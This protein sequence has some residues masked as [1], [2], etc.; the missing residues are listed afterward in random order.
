MYILGSVSFSVQKTA[1]HH[2]PPRIY[3]QLNSPTKAVAQS[4]KF[5]NNKSLN[6]G[7]IDATNMLSSW[8]SIAAFLSRGRRERSECEKIKEKEKR[9]GS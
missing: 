8:P 6:L 7:V 1:S 9:M 3:L 2:L 5:Y 4:L